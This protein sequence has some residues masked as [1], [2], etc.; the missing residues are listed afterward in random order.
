MSPSPETRAGVALRSPG[1]RT[2]GSQR[3]LVAG[4]DLAVV[5]GQLGRRPHAMSGVVRRC[6]HGLPAVVETLP[7][8]GAGRPFPTLFYAT[9]P[10]LVAAVG[11]LEAGGGVRRFV[12]R[13][14]AEA[15]LARSLDAAVRYARRRRAALVA[16]FRLPMRDC[17][18][19][20][21]TGIGGVADARV[22]KCLHAHAAHALAR[23]GYRLGEA[24]LAE[25]G[26]RW[27][28]DRRC[29]AFLP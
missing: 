8:D 16:G 19:S 22:L 23:P 9:C 24:V 27:C 28:A 15:D 13:R 12:R 1:F 26:E 6:P 14:E 7:Y 18:A 20:L 4:D 10:T 2:T 29:A 21:R 11:A 25:A 17:G 5:V 3:R